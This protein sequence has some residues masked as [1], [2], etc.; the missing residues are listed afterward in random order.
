[1]NTIHKSSSK[2]SVCLV[3]YNRY[4]DVLECL[5]SIYKSTYRNFE[6]LVFDNHSKRRLTSKV[7]SKYPHLK[8]FYGSKNV[9][10]A[11]GRSFCEKRAKGEYFMMLDDDTII[12]ANMIEELVQAME[13]DSNIG[14]VGPKV[15]FYDEGKTNILLSGLGRI[16]KLTTLCKDAVY[17]KSDQG[18]FD[19]VASID[20]SQDGFM[21]RKNVADLVGG[22]DVRLVMTY[23]ETDYFIRVQMKG[24][25][26]LFI[27][28]ARL[29]H[30]V[31]LTSRKSSILR[32]ELGLVR[33]G[34]I[35]YNMRNRSVFAKRYFS[36][37]AKVIYILAM[38]HLFFLFYLYKFV[39]YKAPKAYFTNLFKGY[40]EGILIFSG[41]KKL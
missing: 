37:G 7:L 21:V 27:P 36:P 17:H 2:V 30:K 39:I 3:T 9:G 20:Y 12:D 35:Y 23:M 5:D 29:W 22:H 4:K 1:M 24:Y 18:Q 38:V 8:Y 11:G 40:L 33:S 41:M 19:Y 16:S 26:T 28:S 32:D 15:F 34:R 10:G 13:A 25:K 14:M 6:V 31:H